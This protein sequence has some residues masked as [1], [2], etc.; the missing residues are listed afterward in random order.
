MSES[1]LPHSIALSGREQVHKLDID[2]GKT[3][4]ASTKSSRAGR[5][6]L[7]AASATIS[8][9]RSGDEEQ[10]APRRPAGA[11]PQRTA[12]RLETRYPP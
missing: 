3:P 5:S 1:W 12:A 8:S 11:A 10:V 6:L 2:G 9:R 4:Q 7:I